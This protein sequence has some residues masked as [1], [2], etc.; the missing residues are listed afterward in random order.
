MGWVKRVEYKMSCNWKVFV[1]NYLD[2]GYHVEFLHPTLT[3]NLD[4]NSYTTSTAP[5]YSLQEVGGKGTER[6]GSNALFFFLYPSLMINRYGPWMDTNMVVPTGHDS[7]TIV[8]DYY[9]ENQLLNKMSENEKTTFIEES[10]T[11]SN[12]VQEEDNMICESV[13]RGLHSSAYDVGRYAPG[14]EKDRQSNY[15][16]CCLWLRTKL[17]LIRWWYSENGLCK[18]TV[19]SDGCTLYSVHCM[20]NDMQ[21]A[22]CILHSKHIININEYICINKII[23]GLY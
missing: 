10:L 12:Q 17:G 20:N 9:L 19:Y 4:M 13:Q 5:H 21:I 1:D 3:D 2:G 22:H 8:Y 11:A 14:V 15:N 23:Y 7:C 18:C 16:K 6:I